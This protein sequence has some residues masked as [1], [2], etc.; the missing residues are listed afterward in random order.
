MRQPKQK[1]LEVKKG[2]CLVLEY[3]DVDVDVYRA[4][5]IWNGCSTVFYHMTSSVSRQDKPNRAL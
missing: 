5:V 4:H 3:V 2:L 1:Q